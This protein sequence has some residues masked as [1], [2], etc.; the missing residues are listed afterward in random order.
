MY[1]SRTFVGSQKNWTTLTKEAYAIYTTFK[2]LS[3][4]LYG[5]SIN[6]KCDHAALCKFLTAQ[7]LSSKVNDSGTEIACMHHVTLST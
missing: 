1:V 7:T 3:Y 2:K 4:H 6:I 5:A